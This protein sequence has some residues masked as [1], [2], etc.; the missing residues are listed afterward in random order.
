MPTR[1]YENFWT[2]YS[3]TYDVM[4][5]SIICGLYEMFFIDYASDALSIGTAS[6]DEVLIKEH[7]PP[8]QD[9]LAFVY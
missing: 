4:R 5:E 7:L 2:E 6:A 8:V 3:R 1:N 9:P